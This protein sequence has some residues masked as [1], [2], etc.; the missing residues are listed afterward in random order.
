MPIQKILTHD[1]KQNKK[2]QTLLNIL[3]YSNEKNIDWFPSN[4]RK[5][6][7]PIHH[8]KENNKHS[9]KIQLIYLMVT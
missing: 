6:Y 9:P 2:N 3:N 7:C 1:Q 5:L 4:S 8:G